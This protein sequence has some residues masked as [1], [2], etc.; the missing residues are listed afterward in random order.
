MEFTQ[1]FL[2][3]VAWGYW[4]GAVGSPGL[5]GQGGSLLLVWWPASSQAPQ[6][7]TAE[8]C[9]ESG[10]GWSPECTPRWGTVLG[11]TALTWTSGLCPLPCGQGILPVMWAPGASGAR[12]EG[13][14]L[15]P[16]GSWAAEC[17]P[18]PAQPGTEGSPTLDTHSLL[19]WNF[20][21]P[22]EGGQ[23]GL[24]VSP[25]GHQALTLS[26]PNSP[27]HQRNSGP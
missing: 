25:P 26:P 27:T 4:A 8:G 6:C 21:Q 17:L 7:G 11:L 5:E 3:P 20:T 9:R 12:G 14:D 19:P 13:Q 10:G 15:L 2:S 18:G 22:G 1:S 24:G 16:G 23:N